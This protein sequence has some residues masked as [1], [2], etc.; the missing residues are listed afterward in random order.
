VCRRA[1]NFKVGDFV[2][3]RIRPERLPNNFLKKLHARA[4]G[5][6]KIIQQ[7]GSNAYVLDLLGSLGVSHIFNVEDLNLHQGTFGPLCLPF[8]VFAGT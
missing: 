3:A 8:G 4:I 1:L 5:P 7:L 6:Y 2:L